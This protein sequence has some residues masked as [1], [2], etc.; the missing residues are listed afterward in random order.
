MITWRSES[1]AVKPGQARGR[2]KENDKRPVM[3]LFS[4]FDFD[5]AR[6]QLFDGG[7][8]VHLTPKAFDLL[9]LLIEA[10]PRVVPK[11]ELHERLW[12]GAV[13]SDATLVGLVK[14]LRRALGDHDQS[15]PM[16][17]TAHRVGYAFAAPLSEAAR[18]ARVARWLLAGE[19]RIPLAEG[20]NIVGR[21][22]QSKVWID[23]ATVSRRHARIV[24]ND[25]C[26]LLE[27]LG[28]KNGTMVGENRVVDA[29]VLRDGDRIRFGEMLVSYRESES[30][31][32]TL[33]QVSR[34]GPSA[35]ER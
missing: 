5:F 32:P 2:F 13:V 14:E 31:F 12:R 3:T 19:R 30:G 29:V 23:H 26:A 8:E 6:R 15:A 25:S 18:S 1:L 4:S 7:R 35:M 24:G 20:E 9:A 28:S 34:V 33:T 27:D 21:D 22:P 16:I 11:A 17:R 10:T